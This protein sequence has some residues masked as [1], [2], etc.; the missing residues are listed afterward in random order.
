MNIRDIA[1]TPL[2][3]EIARGL[4]RASGSLARARA[5]RRAITDLL[6]IPEDEFLNGRGVDRVS[7]PRMVSM[8]LC[9]R[10]TLLSHHDI[11]TL[12]NRSNHTTVIHA[13][14]KY[15]TDPHF[16]ELLRTIR[17]LTGETPATQ[18]A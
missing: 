15:G 14:R 16:L 11:K 9:R 3:L 10:L 17:A 1:T 5:I 12:H 18:P 13:V 4:R 2:A 8:V 7:R 6:R